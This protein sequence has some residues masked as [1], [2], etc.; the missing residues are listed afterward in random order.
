MAQG[1]PPHHE[2]RFTGRY[3]KVAHL[4]SEGEIAHHASHQ[5]YKMR[6]GLDGDMWQGTGSQ[7]EYEKADELPLCRNCL[8]QVNAS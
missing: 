6:C 2:R 3:P 7:D 1:D 5:W 8:K 4:V